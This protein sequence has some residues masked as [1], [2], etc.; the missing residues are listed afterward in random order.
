MSV[1]TGKLVFCLV[2][3]GEPYPVFCGRRC[4]SRSLW[5]QTLIPEAFR[6]RR[7]LGGHGG[8]V[9]AEDACL[10]ASCCAAVGRSGR[11]A[12]PSAAN[13]LRQSQRPGLVCG[14]SP[15]SRADAG[16]PEVPSL[17]APPLS[18]P[19]LL[20][21]RVAFCCHHCLSLVSRVREGA[22]RARSW[23]GRW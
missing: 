16:G 2:L 22:G 8:G 15:C 4:T 3:Q 23:L 18:P 9:A 5:G 12:P 17:P 6:H 10:H 19:S 1:S 13:S 20:S 11:A 7:N 14:L 21:G